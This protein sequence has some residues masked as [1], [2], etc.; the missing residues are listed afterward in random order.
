MVNKKTDL[1]EAIG[2]FTEIN[3]HKIHVYRIGDQNKPKLVLMAGSSTVAP[4]YDFKIL[5]TKLMEY[6]RII[7]VEKFG[8]GYS[9]IC[10]CDCDIDSL[11]NIQRE[12]LEKLGENGPFILMPHS[13]AGIEAIRWIQ[14][15]PEE[16]SALIGLDMTS[17]TSYAEWSDSDVEK[18]I[19]LLSRL[20]KL[21]LYQLSTIPHNDLLTGNDKKQVKLLQKRN[22]FNE[23]YGRE[24]KRVRENAAIVRS[25]GPISCPTLLF[26]SNG[27][28]TFKN[29]LQNQQYF[30]EVMNARLITYDCGHYIHYY[31][32]DQMS[33]EIISFIDS[34]IQTINR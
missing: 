30:A 33:K 11:V 18:R 8:Y 13:M 34:L 22:A 31:M 24:A 3:G 26:S 10:E 5:Y 4:V 19:R 25:H 32:S 23:C 9:D 27:K 21:G 17:G 28:Q 20:R 7:I 16:V 15:Y 6:Y 14:M 12:A 2:E 29:W 1:P